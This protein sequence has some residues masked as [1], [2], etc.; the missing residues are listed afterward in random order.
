[1]LILVCLSEKVAAV[2]EKSAVE[3]ATRQTFVPAEGD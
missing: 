3:T 1:M 2:E